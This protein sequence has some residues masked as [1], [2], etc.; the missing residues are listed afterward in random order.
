VFGKGR[1]RSDAPE[2][3]ALD[4]LWRTYYAHI[5]NPARLKVAAMRSEMPQKYWRNLPEARLIRPLI[6]SAEARAREMVELAPT[7]PAPHAAA[8]RRQF[9]VQAT[10]RGIDD[11]GLRNCARCP[12]AAAATQAVPGE[13][14]R[15]ARVM[16]I[17]EQPGDEEDLSGRP[18]V[19]PAGRLLDRALA[20]AGL[21]RAGLYLTNA[22]KHFKFERRGKRRIHKRPGTTEIEHCAWWLRQELET[23]D[24]EI[25]VALG[26]TAA[27]ALLGRDVRIAEIRGR[28][29]PLSERARLMITVHP[30]YVLR[31]PNAEQR[32]AFD[33]LAA[34]LAQVRDPAALPRGQAA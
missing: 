15:D 31:L 16:L 22:V 30:A 23:L 34:D 3:D 12:L 18:F 11:D 4:D 28:F 1:R 24:P 14:P 27:R 32:R 25:I 2:G 26:A 8:A 9:E 33:V 17:G 5:F 10:T 7:L 19:G 29:L 21:D 6:A 13:G 20:E